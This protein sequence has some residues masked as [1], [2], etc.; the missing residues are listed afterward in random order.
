MQAHERRQKDAWDRRSAVASRR[1]AGILLLDDF[2]ALNP[3][4]MAW[5]NLSGLP[6][7]PSPRFGH[8]FAGAGSRLYLLGGVDQNYGESRDLEGC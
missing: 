6:A 5:T 8:G 2:F 1:A 4:R 3:A 7:A